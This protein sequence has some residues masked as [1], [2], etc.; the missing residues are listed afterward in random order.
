M[1]IVCD[2]YKFVYCQIPKN[3]CSAIK[4]WILELNDDPK[5]KNLQGPALLRYIHTH[6]YKT[7]T[8]QQYL[9]VPKY[10]QYTLFTIVRNPYLRLVS[11]FKD[12]FIKAYKN[13][14]A[15]IWKHVAK[16]VT[17]TQ[18]INFNQFVNYIQPS[19]NDLYKGNGHWRLQTALTNIN[20][21]K[22]DPRMP[23]KEKNKIF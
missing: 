16:S 1:L 14:P 13:E 5:I 19:Q 17:K 6:K 9:T 18:Y 23:F 21:L 2:K 11:A 12:R 15:T 20:T 8:P 7:I 22:Y 4:K 10:K 3:A